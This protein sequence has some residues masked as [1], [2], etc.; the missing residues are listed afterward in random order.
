MIYSGNFSK[1]PLTYI[2]PHLLPAVLSEIMSLDKICLVGAN[3]TLGSVVLTSLLEG[4]FQVTILQRNNSSSKFDKHPNLSIKLVDPDFPIPEIT[5]ALR[6]QDAVVVTFPLP[7]RL[8]YHLRL[9]YAAAQAGV[10]RFIPADFGSCDS[11]DPEALRRLQLFR[12][13]VRVRERCDELSLE[14]QSASGSNGFSWTSIVGGH[15]F[16]YGLHDGL[17]HFDLD[18]KEALLLDGGNIPASAS[19]LPRLGEAVVAV[20][21]NPSNTANKTLY[22]QSFNPT[23]RQVLASL[24]KA[25]G[26]EAWKIKEE[27]SGPFLDREQKRL[28]ED[29][30]KAAIEEIVFA[31]G[32][33]DADWTKKD[34][35][36]MELL[37]MKDDD[38]DLVVQ[39]VVDEHRKGHGKS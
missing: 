6:G 7:N 29:G 28:D 8:E 33:L 5:A 20:L 19:T 35:F 16:D 10:R 34:G 36:A 24:E 4:K 22:V 12:D 11:Q 31:L 13:K 38:L 18:K 25:T 39:R 21:K 17:L 27:A 30:E 1:R 3:G 9:A 14:Y 15:F 23:Q 2:H 32:T 26:G 37:G